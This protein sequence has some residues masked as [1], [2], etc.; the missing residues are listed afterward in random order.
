MIFKKI[1]VTIDFVGLHKRKISSATKQLF[2]S[3]ERGFEL[4][5]LKISH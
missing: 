4:M 3:Q 1:E 5:I 2:V